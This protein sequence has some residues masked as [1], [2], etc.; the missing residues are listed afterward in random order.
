MLYLAGGGAV[1]GE[2]QDGGGGD[3]DLHGGPQARA[4][5]DRPQVKL[6]RLL[7]GRRRR[8]RLLLLRRRLHQRLLRSRRR[9]Q[10]RPPWPWSPAIVHRRRQGRRNGAILAIASKFFLSFL[11][12]VVSYILASCV[13]GI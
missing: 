9:E 6:H 7:V 2:H 11:A 4:Y 13:L 8:P 1:R 12:I 10:R 3:P 5:D